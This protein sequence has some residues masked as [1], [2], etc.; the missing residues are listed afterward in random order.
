M[1]EHSVTA[2]DPASVQW[3][4]GRITVEVV[5]IAV[6]I[7]PPAWLVLH[8]PRIPA[9]SPRI[10]HSRMYLW[11]M[12]AY[13]VAL[14]LALSEFGLLSKMHILQ[15]GHRLSGLKR[16]FTAYFLA[17]RV[18]LLAFLA[19]LSLA[20]DQT[21]VTGRVWVARSFIAASLTVVALTI[22]LFTVVTT[23]AGYRLIRAPDGWKG[24]WR[25]KA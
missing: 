7:V 24:Y 4:W 11:M 17:A 20:M 25:P 1:A 2:E 6:L 21:A 10:H 23:R 15:R 14:Y 22:L 16:F 8:W 18:E 12:P 19:V 3:G 13:M 5:T 9:T